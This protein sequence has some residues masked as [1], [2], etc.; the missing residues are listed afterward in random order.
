MLEERELCVRETFASPTHRLTSRCLFPSTNCTCIGINHR[1]HACTNLTAQVD[2]EE[3]QE[4][5]PIP[6]QSA[7]SQQVTPRPRSMSGTPTPRSPGA[8]AQSSGFAHSPSN[9]GP[10][11]KSAQRQGSIDSSDNNTIPRGSGYQRPANGSPP[12]SPV[13]EVRGG[14]SRAPRAPGPLHNHCV[15]CVQ[16]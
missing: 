13:S 11:R 12:V 2:M 5:S 16:R 9:L 1:R 4:L 7:T 14:G 3:V 10:G 6:S 15:L 8:Y